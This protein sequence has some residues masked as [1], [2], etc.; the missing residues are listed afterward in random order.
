MKYTFS[1]LLLFAFINANSQKVAIDPVITPSLFRY[2]DAIT[3]VYDV[4]GTS[5]A[6]LNEAFIW[7]WIPGRNIDAK[8]NVNP[9]SNDVTKTNNA[10]F[11][12]STVDGKTLFTL[13]FTPSSFF[14]GDIG[15]DT[16]IG[17][18]LK[19]NDWANGQTTDYIASFWDGSF[20]V[21]LT[22]PLQRPLFVETGD[23]ITIAAETP[24]A[25]NFDLF[26]NDVLIDEQ[27][28][29]ATYSYVHTVQETT[30]G[31]TV[32]LIATDGANSSE[33]AFQYLI[34]SPSPVAARPSGIIPG[35]NYPDD[36]TKVVLCLWA[37]GKTSA[38]VLG[39][40][41]DWD[42]LPNY[43]MNRDGE[44]F[45]LEI[46]GLT[47]FQQYAFQ[48]LVEE[49][50]FI[51]DPYADMILDPDDQYIPDD[52]YP[53]LKSF[54]QK[55]LK[56]EW[57]F[58]RLS[59]LQT[60]QDNIFIGDDGFVKPEKE[61]LVIYELLIRDFFENGERSYLNLRDTLSYF[62][63]LGV[64]AI[65]LM[66]VMEFNGNESWGY[67]PTFMFAPDK[68]YGEKDAFKSFIEAC[69][70]N[71]IAVILDIALNH[72]DL[73]NPYL[74]MDFDFSTFKPTAVNKWFN[75]SATHPFSVFYDMNHE[76]TYTQKYVDTINYYWL[77]EYKVDGFRFDLSKGF[78][79]T[80]NPT[81]VEA[82]SNYDPSRIAIL[83]RMA[84]KIW[85][86]T[87]DAYIIL[88][89]L[90]VNSEEKELAEY[91]AAEGKGMMLWGKMTDQYS[92]AMMGYAENNNIS[93]VYHGTRGWSVPHLI[94]YMESHDE[95]R[96]MY[97]NI[98]YG[99]A[100]A[101]HNTR[102]TLTALARL[103]AAS[104]IFY[105]IPGPKMLWQFGE[106]GYDYSINY[107]PDGSN[108]SNCRISP[109]PVRWDYR[110]EANR[111]FLYEHISDLIRLRNF[112][113]V[114]TNGEAVITS[115]NSL[116]E[117]IVLK[118]DPYT[119]SPA[120]ADEMNAVVV[121]NLDLVDRQISVTFPHSGSWYDYYQGGTEIE[122]SSSTMS[123]T[124]V[125][126]GYKIYTDYPIAPSS[127]TGV[128]E[129]IKDDLSVYPNPVGSSFAV[130]SQD[131]SR[132]DDARIYNAQGKVL[133]LH[134][135]SDEAWDASDLAPG[136]YLL[137]VY[138]KDRRISKKILKH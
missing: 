76:S 126:G 48:Y 87:P 75:I 107:C 32:T 94:G 134:R 27:N 9:A 60:D 112:S 84:D 117:Q 136:I 74:M 7:V 35:I 92:Q 106:L 4:T 85:S 58:N 100:S 127:I 118:N 103:R 62:K 132:I 44:Y 39:D 50:I 40:F 130:K 71:G 52:V 45:W 121:T 88:E 25:A 8:Y 22:S 2:N 20:Q 36:S 101:S 137:N 83:K 5:L 120:N 43:I 81:N 128:E 38:Y 110:E 33:K 12:K 6:T 34:S 31:S 18:L 99:N 77:N 129:S 11:T 133:P 17:M 95:E 115:D 72:Q 55:A 104:T 54:P 124:L 42:V 131:G 114:F 135:L 57:Y 29:V 47:P 67:N 1:C 86:H 123:L 59:V 64:N 89:H 24:V 138:T 79:Q 13:T 37:P 49:S 14:D 16:Q 46:T 97:K 116:V 23:E 119:E 26:I 21:Q 111:Y 69:H 91:R 109:K 19:G 82:W 15:T 66:P 68:Y 80:N 102:D 122:V 41:T 61:K 98:L 51:A 105:T 96:M 30:G 113:D 93:G 53:N 56:G 28:G 70:T 63:K 10:K 90:S 73:P 3:V 65:E 78:T 125:P 108:N